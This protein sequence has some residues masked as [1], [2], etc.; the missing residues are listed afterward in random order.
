MV[1][2]SL[3]HVALCAIADEADVVFTLRAERSGEARRAGNVSHLVGSFEELLGALAAERMDA[4]L[5]VFAADHR[6]RRS[7]LGTLIESRPRVAVTI[8]ILARAP[9]DLQTLGALPWHDR[10][11]VHWVDTSVVA[12]ASRLVLV[13]MGP[14][15]RSVPL[16]LAPTAFDPAAVE[17]TVTLRP[18]P[19]TAAARAADNDSAP[20][21]DR[22][23][24]SPQGSTADRSEA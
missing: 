16:D 11:F 9:A 23:G 10:E 13:G 8:A 7:D 6:N 20:T 21:H 18:P 5:V 19:S 3:D 1:L 24:G 22:W 17:A 12:G 4:E 14:T 15:P 2:G